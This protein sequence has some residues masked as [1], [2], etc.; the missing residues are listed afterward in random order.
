[1]HT[2]QTFRSGFLGSIVAA[3]TLLAGC[4]GDAGGPSDLLLIDYASGGG[5]A[6]IGDTVRATAIRLVGGSPAGDPGPITWHSSDSVIA[7]IGADGLITA[8]S[9]GVTQIVATAGGRTGS[10]PFSVGGTLHRTAITTDEVWTVATG[11]HIVEGVLPVGSPAGVVLTIE[12]GTTVFF[13]LNAGLD[14]GSG[15]S[16]RVVADG[17]LA[18]IT[19]AGGGVNSIQDW[20]GLTF[21]G[22]GQSTLRNVA[23][24][25]CGGRFGTPTPCIALRD[26][27]NSPAPTILMDSV[28][29]LQS[30]T[31]GVVLEGRARFVPGSRLLSVIQMNGL[32]AAIPL[33][34]AQEFPVGGLMLS[35]ATNEIRLIPGNDT[36]ATSTTWGNP[37]APWHLQRSLIVEGP[38]QPVFTIDSGASL[39]FDFNVSITAGQG[40]P[41]GLMVGASTGPWV[42]ITGVGND[43]WGGLHFGHLALFSR[44]TRTT[45]HRCGTAN[46]GCL[47]LGAGYSPGDPPAAVLDSVT[48]LAAD[49]FGVGANR[50]GAGSRALRVSGSI[51]FPMIVA[52]DAVATIPSGSYTGNAADAIIISGGT[53]PDSATWIDHGVPY[54]AQDFAVEGPR[55]PMLT[56]APGV[57]IRFNLNTQMRVGALDPGG[58][59]VLGL[60]GQPVTLTSQQPASPGYWRGVLLGALADSNSMI[61][62]ALVDDAGASQNGPP[63]AAVSVDHDIGPVVQH[64]IL[65]HSGHCG[66]SRG[67]GGAWTTDFTAAAL[68]NS[69]LQNGGPDQC[70]P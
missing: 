65:Q 11:P 7:S 8:R 44:V 56:L 40:A 58:L 34:A 60:P 26:S 32:V 66:I 64:S 50:F 63:E 35:N 33:A 36:I 9:F 38:A 29:I 52:S 27:S 62:Y 1:M 43:T 55:N 57:V 37:G 4:A 69:F 19:L 24:K 21:H 61:D 23:L 14:V 70:D 48:I 68:G 15:G 42:D 13:H 5:S 16:G 28:A 54:L 25:Y 10:K 31:A 18:P 17:A 39:I 53:V 51:G 45:L 47:T 22:P 59:R 49:G 12:P 6:Y 30:A 41:G 46:A 3:F 67:T 20:G 2:I